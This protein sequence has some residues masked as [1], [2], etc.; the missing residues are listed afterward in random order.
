MVSHVVCNGLY[1]EVIL[2]ASLEVLE[3]ILHSV[4]TESL[5]RRVIV[6]A[7]LSAKEDSVALL[8]VGIVGPSE[9]GGGL[10]QLLCIKARGVCE[11]RQ[12][13]ICRF[14]AAGNGKRDCKYEEHLFHMYMFSL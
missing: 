11:C 14:F 1:A 13:L 12:C 2:Y 5:D 7:V 4:R 6:A 10:V 9:L 3:Y 8:A